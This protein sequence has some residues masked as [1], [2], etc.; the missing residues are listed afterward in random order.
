MLSQ[1]EPVYTQF[2]S[3]KRII[4]SVSNSIYSRS[5]WLKT[6][7]DSGPKEKPASKSVLPNMVETVIEHWECGYLE[8]RCTVSIKYTTDL[9]SKY[10]KK[11][12]M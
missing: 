3:A 9:K 12:R 7:L 2:K 1:G 6:P 8:L 5:F 11:K 10:E 4:S